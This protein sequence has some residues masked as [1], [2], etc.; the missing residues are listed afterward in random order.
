MLVR[1]RITT[2]PVKQLLQAR[3][4]TCNPIQPVMEPCIIGGCHT[5]LAS[6]SH[7]PAWESSALSLL[8]SRCDVNSPKPHHTLCSREVLGFR[9]GGTL[10]R[11]LLATRMKHKTGMNH[12]L[13]GDNFHMDHGPFC[14][15]QS[16]RGDLAND[17]RLGRRSKVEAACHPNGVH[18]PGISRA[19]Q[20]FLILTLTFL[21]IGA[22]KAKTKSKD[23]PA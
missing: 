19:L 20:N 11:S 6:A 5:P 10:A 8:L 15:Q 4:D 9:R 23:T 2:H 12:E 1:D 3:P 7:A 18:Q 22:N 14:P 17:H 21:K 16:A 13:N